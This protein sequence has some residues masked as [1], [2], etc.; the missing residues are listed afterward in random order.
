[1]YGC[2]SVVCA[3]VPVYGMSV[4]LSLYV[5]DMWIEY[6]WYIGVWHVCVL[7]VVCACVFCLSEQCVV[8]WVML[9]SCPGV[10]VGMTLHPTALASLQ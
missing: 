8:L 6:M 1:M 2:I 9:C 5:Y 10:F 4:C 7:F 3:Y